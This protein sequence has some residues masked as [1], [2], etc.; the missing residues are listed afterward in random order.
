MSA[1]TRDRCTTENAFQRRDAENAEEAQRKPKPESL[2]MSSL[3][4]CVEETSSGASTLQMNERKFLMAGGG[5]GG[6]V[7]PGLA[8]ARELRTRGHQV[9]FV[10]T[11]FGIEAKLVPAAG[12]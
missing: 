12:R 8:V 10:G 6:H 4:L 1:S 9:S 11:E 5:T 7:I 2:S 3:R